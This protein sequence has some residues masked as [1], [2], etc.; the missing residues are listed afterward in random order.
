M[1][2]RV[3]VFYNNSWGTIC[4]DSWDINDGQVVCRMLGFSGVISAPGGAQFGQGEGPIVLDEVQCVGSEEDLLEC[5]RNSFLEH[6]CGHSED[7]GV[8]CHNG[9]CK[10][11]SNCSF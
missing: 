8:V 9:S 6:N 2:G 4:D 10:F 11:N 1:E 3:E 5:Q 7:A